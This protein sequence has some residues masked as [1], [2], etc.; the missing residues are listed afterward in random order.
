MTTRRR[1][2]GD[3]VLLLAGLLVLLLALGALAALL[4]DV[5]IESA[6]GGAP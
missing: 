4:L 1:L 6:D 3:R 5:F 2:L